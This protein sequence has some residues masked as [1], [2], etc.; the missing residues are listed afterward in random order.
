[1]DKPSKS[2]VFKQKLKNFPFM[3]LKNRSY[4]YLL[5]SFILLL[6]PLWT[7]NVSVDELGPILPIE[8][9]LKEGNFDVDE[10]P[11]IRVNSF[12]YKGHWYS[13]FNPFFG[14]IIGPFRWFG[15]WIGSNLKDFLSFSPLS[16]KALTELHESIR[17]SIQTIPTIISALI[18]AIVI[19]RI[20][21]LWDIH[22]QLRELAGLV[23]LFGTTIRFYAISTWPHVFGSTLLITSYFLILLLNR[24][25][26]NDLSYNRF[27]NPEI[28]YSFFI[29][30]FLGVAVLIR[31]SYLPIAILLLLLLLYSRKI[32][33]LIIVGISAFPWAFMFFSYNYFLFD[34]PLTTPHMLYGDAT[35]R[36]G[37]EILPDGF[38]GNFLA[39]R[40]SIFIFAPIFLLFPLSII[41]YKSNPEKTNFVEISV[42][43]L[44]IFFLALTASLAKVWTGDYSWGPRYI[45]ETVPAL[46]LLSWLGLDVVIK[47]LNSLSKNTR[48]FTK[49][50]V[51]FA[52]IWGVFLNTI[53]AFISPWPFYSDLIQKGRL[54]SY[55]YDEWTYNIFEY[56]YAVWNY[57]IIVLL[58]EGKFSSTIIQA[59][60]L[61]FPLLGNV[62]GFLLLFGSIGL[63]S[64]LIIN[65]LWLRNIEE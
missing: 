38:F 50:T 51:T 45:T 4:S 40:A 39:P 5:I 58:P 62:F 9:F 33:I 14:I 30:T 8:S 47:K 3:I 20:L 2:I 10:Y 60:K 57:L 23:Y 22:P 54:N 49:V 41:W 18:G 6:I 13:A 7:D 52:M 63:V 1:M 48:I 28:L 61:F 29:G 11:S 17:H 21:T 43:Y 56:P 26:D 55:I 12:N 16:E 24:M 65:E 42:L 31:E 35:G 44:W 32:K 19:V 27:F 37:W 34:N 53:P 46:L 36:T 25:D 64:L 59:I 15:D